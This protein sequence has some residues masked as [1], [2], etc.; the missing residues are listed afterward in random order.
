MH[1]HFKTTCRIYILRQI[2]AYQLPN[3][4]FFNIF[5]LGYFVYHY[6]GARGTKIDSLFF[7]VSNSLIEDNVSYQ[8]ISSVNQ[9]LLFLNK[10]KAL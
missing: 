1:F 8:K 6:K 4:V 2:R 5:K 7:L 3:T 9:K 10:V